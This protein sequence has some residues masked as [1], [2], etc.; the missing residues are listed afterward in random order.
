MKLEG[1]TVVVTG[2]GG[3]IGGHLVESLHAMGCRVRVLTS[4]S[5]SRSDGG[6]GYLKTDVRQDLEVFRGD[7]RDRGSVAR[8]MERGDVV[9]HLA[10]LGEVPY[11]FEAPESYVA[12]N[13]LGT[14]NVLEE[15]R[16][17]QFEKVVLTST[18]AVYGRPEYLPVDEKHPVKAGSPYGSSKI[19]GEV[20]GES[21]F[22]S[23]EIP[24]CSVRPFNTY[25]PRQST[26]AIIPSMIEQ[27]LGDGNEIMVGDLTPT[28]DMVFVGD[29][30]KAFIKVA[31]SESAAGHVINIA[32]GREVA[33][34]TVVE[35]LIKLIKPGVSIVVDQ[36]RVRNSQSGEDRIF[37]CPR[38]LSEIAGWAPDTGLVEGLT[39]TVEWFQRL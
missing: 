1:K 8:V 36:A 23:F 33:M 14:M 24:V 35:E 4:Y 11:S 22:R 7:I 9:F 31:E 18:A 30:V 16:R 19:C 17:N 38:K 34:Q 10:G 28:R 3:F 21:Y 25:G 6:L 29:T 5:S 12:T 32:T 13:V 27:L 15:S 39:E 20:L 37:G 26:R 2:A